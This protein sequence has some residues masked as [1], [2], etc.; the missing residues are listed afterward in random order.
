MKN[1]HR[2]VIDNRSR[3]DC[4]SPSCLYAVMG[5]PSTNPS[6]PNATIGHLSGFPLKACGNDELADCHA[7]RP[8][9]GI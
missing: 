9:S 3:M 4:L 1:H 8:P 7:R 5:I 6:Y 2:P